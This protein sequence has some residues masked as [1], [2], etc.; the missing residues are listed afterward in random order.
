MKKVLTVLC[1]IAI[2]ACLVFAFSGCEC[3]HED[4]N[5]DG[6]CDGCDKKLA[7]VGLEYSLN[8]D[9]KSY[10]VIGMGEATDTDVIIPPKHNGLPVTAIGDKA[11]KGYYNSAVKVESIIVPDSVTEIGYGAFSG[12][13]TLKSVSLGKGITKINRHT[14]FECWALKS[15]DL[16]DG[17]TEIGYMAFA[18]CIKLESIKLPE[19]L[20]VI[21]R[22]AFYNCSALK[23]VEIPDLVTEIRFLAFAGCN[24]VEYFT[25]GSRVRVLETGVIPETSKLKWIVVPKSVQTVHGGAFPGET[26]GTELYFEAESA[27]EDFREGWNQ[28]GA[29]VYFA[30]EWRYENGVPTPINK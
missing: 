13:L 10:T 7:T 8:A 19:Q 6:F 22:E 16:P 12:S 14:F 5:G 9:G 30:G 26:I 3:S 2:S 21:D 28:D 1:L 29:P 4:T 11:F 15:V 17:V 27:G 18:Y 23:K 20:V 24:N 25:L